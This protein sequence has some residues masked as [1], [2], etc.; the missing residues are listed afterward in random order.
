MDINIIF[1]I[2]VL[3]FSIIVHEV[4]HGYAADKLGDPTA[5]MQGR[6]TLN[7]LSHI[8]PIGSIIVPFLSY[9]AGF[10]F[11]W[12]KPVPFNPYNLK[13]QRSGESI[14]A[15]AGPLSNIFLALVAGLLLRNLE[16]FTFLANSRAI[17]EVAVIVNL[18]LALFN[19][20]PV[21]PLD[22]S[23]ILFAVLPYRLMV[24]TRGFLERYGL[25][26]MIPVILFAGRIIIVPL[27]IGFYL[28]TGSAPQLW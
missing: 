21:P 9:M 1:Y 10:P 8:D 2:V 28:I 16:L 13:N 3:A 25:L 11:G 20:I 14:I 6:L 26:L 5:R 22:G 7:P 17:L 15:L 12:A 19:L 23:K 24:H 18:A 4:S 27:L